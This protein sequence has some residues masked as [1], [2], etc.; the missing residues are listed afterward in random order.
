MY[1]IVE[2]CKS[3]GVETVGLPTIVFFL[4]GFTLPTNNSLLINFRLSSDEE[5]FINKH[6][7]SIQIGAKRAKMC[8]QCVHAPN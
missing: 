7:V 4:V 1:P 2:I 6:R 8:M 5:I 3:V